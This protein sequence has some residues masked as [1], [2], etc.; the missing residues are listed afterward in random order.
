MARPYQCRCGKNTAHEGSIGN[1][2]AHSSSLAGK[3]T[4]FASTVSK[5]VGLKAA[6]EGLV[7]QEYEVEEAARRV[8]R[9]EARHRRT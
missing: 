2:M 3:A 8:A 5:A 9:E 4:R 6:W 1:P 7:G